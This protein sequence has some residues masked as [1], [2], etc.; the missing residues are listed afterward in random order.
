MRLWLSH[1]AFEGC[2]REVIG[3]MSCP[4]LTN[5]GISH[6]GCDGKP[7]LALRIVPSSTNNFQPASFPHMHGCLNLTIAQC[8]LHVCPEGDNAEVSKM[9]N[10]LG[11]LRIQSTRLRTGSSSAFGLPWRMERM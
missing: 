8:E 6:C 5:P 9:M 11:T 3:A 4:G 7:P 1:A 10:M 2:C